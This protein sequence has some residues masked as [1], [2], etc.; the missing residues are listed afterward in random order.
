M[1]WIQ[2][3][4]E[5]LSLLLKKHRLRYVFKIFHYQ[6]ISFGKA[7]FPAALFVVVKDEA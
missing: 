2:G 1:L 7:I 4:E 5:R 3:E 6:T